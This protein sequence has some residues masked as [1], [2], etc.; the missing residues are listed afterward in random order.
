[1]SKRM[2]STYRAGVVD[3]SS[4]KSR[5]RGRVLTLRFGEFTERVVPLRVRRHQ[6]GDL[7]QGRRTGRRPLQ[8]SG[9]LRLATGTLHVHHQGAGDVAGQVR[10]VVLFDE[11]ESQIDSGG[12]SCRGVRAAVTD[13]DRVGF[14]AAR[15][16]SGGELARG[17]PV[18][19]A[20]L[21]A[22]RPAAARMNA[23]VQIDATRRAPA[24]GTRAASARAPAQASAD[25]RSEPATRY[26]SG[27]RSEETAPSTATLNP[28]FDMTSSLSATAARSGNRHRTG[29]TTLK[30]SA[31][32][33]TSN[34]VTPS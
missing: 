25:S 31:G 6:V 22:R 30:T 24:A 29:S 15:R 21:P 9:E 3:S 14:D 12:H 2:Y 18:R 17:L 5:V 1:M 34:R 23:P 7:P 8:W 32:P 26:V 33:A 27:A 13:V 10:S 20:R 19:G 28:R 11:R 16:A 4:W